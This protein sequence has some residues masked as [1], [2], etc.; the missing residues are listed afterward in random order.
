MTLPS[1]ELFVYQGMTW[2]IMDFPLGID[3]KIMT[4]LTEMI[5][6]ML[7]HYSR[8]LV[9]RLDLHQRKYSSD[10]AVVS[11]FFRK[12]IPKLKRK[13]ECKVNYA[14]VREKNKASAQ[15][16]HIA[17]ALSA[18]KIRYPVTLIKMVEQLWTG[19]EQQMP[20]TPK[21]CYYIA[22]RDDATSIGEVLYRL[23]Y[24]AK[25]YSKG[26]KSRH[27]NNYF[28]SRTELSD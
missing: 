22:H 14:W 27:A 7:E 24:L 8:I 1:I 26:R 11:D 12:L 17:I 19:L 20:Y 9:L 23:S 13:Y 21:N 15:H 10:N 2:P 28:V 16:Y 5:D 3:G 4:R 25:H 18:H 6:N